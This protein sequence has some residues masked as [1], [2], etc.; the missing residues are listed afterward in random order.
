MTFPSFYCLLIKKTFSSRLFTSGCNHP[1]SFIRPLTR[2]TRGGESKRS[3]GEIA[4]NLD[5]NLPGNGDEPVCCP[6]QNRVGRVRHTSG[7]AH[8]ICPASSACLG[9]RLS[10]SSV[11]LWMPSSGS[12]TT[13]SDTVG[14]WLPLLP[15]RVRGAHQSGREARQ[16]DRC[17]MADD[18]KSAV[19]WPR[20]AARLGQPGWLNDTMT[21]LDSLVERRRR[22]G[23]PTLHTPLIH[24]C[25]SFSMW[26]WRVTVATGASFL[27]AGTNK[28]N[29]NGP[30]C[31]RGSIVHTGT[32]P[33]SCSLRVRLFSSDLQDGTLCPHGIV[34]CTKVN[35]VA[36]M[37]YLGERSPRLSVFV[38]SGWSILLLPLLFLTLISFSINVQPR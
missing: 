4:L 14:E 9:C 21:R 36:L 2:V 24:I 3:E 10:R 1:F 31:A 25:V 29:D 12:L 35:Y 6:H 23:P 8:R 17:E 7:L 11:Q 38:C 16:P 15:P 28:V 37:Q 22:A 5:V 18:T 26:T 19:V 13:D 32:R 27:E 33:C 30:L 34:S 20:T